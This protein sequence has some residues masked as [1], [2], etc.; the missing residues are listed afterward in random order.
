MAE[1]RTVTVTVTETTV[2]TFQVPIQLLTALELPLSE[3]ARRKREALP[4]S[5]RFDEEMVMAAVEGMSGVEYAVT[6]RDIEF[7][8]EGSDNDEDEE[9]DADAA[10]EERA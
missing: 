3:D 2:E 8:P 6:D 10:D 1:D 7:A 5:E 9:T 4:F